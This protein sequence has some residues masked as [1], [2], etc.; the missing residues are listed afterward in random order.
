MGD[1]LAAD[2]DAAGQ[3]ENQ[4]AERVDFL[5]AFHRDRLEELYG[6]VGKGHASLI[7]IARSASWKHSNWDDWTLD[8]KFYSLGE[9]YAHLIYLVN[10]GRITLTGWPLDL[11]QA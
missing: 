6:L 5:K 1:H 11:R 9:T 7:D 4:P 10:A 3:L 2:R 8:Q